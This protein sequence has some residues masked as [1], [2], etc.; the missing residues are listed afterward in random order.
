MQRLGNLSTA[1]AQL[2]RH[3]KRRRRTWLGALVG[4]AALLVSFGVSAPSGAGA[5]AKASHAKTGGSLTVLE[6]SS[7]SGEWPAGFDPLNGTG[8]AVQSQEDAIYGGLFEWGPKNTI[9]PDLAKSWTFTHDDTLLTLNLRPGVTFQDGT[10][11]DAAAVVYNWE[12][13]L[14]P[15]NGCICLSSF[16]VAPNGITATGPLQVQMKLAH[17]YAAL[18]NAFIGEAPN[19]IA[20]PTAE[21]KLGNR[22]TFYPVGAGPFQVVSD[23]TSDEL[24]LKAFPHYWNKGHPYL[25]HLIFK[26]VTGGDQ[27]AYEAM[28]AGD[29]GVY[30]GLSTFSL[31]PT[32]KKHFRVTTEP[33]TSVLW[34]QLN[35]DKA[36]FNKLLAREAIYEATNSQQVNKVLDDDTEIPAE[37]FTTPAGLFFTGLKVPGYI[38]Y[39]PAKARASVKKLHGIDFTIGYLSSPTDQVLAEVLAKEYEAVGMKVGFDP[40]DL[41]LEIDQYR[42]NKLQMELATLGAYDPAA[43]LGVSFRLASN[44]PFSFVH[45]PQMDAILNAAASSPVAS[46]RKADYL[47]AEELMTKEA[48]G[49]ML[50]AGPSLEVSAHDVHGPGF[51]SSL[52]AVELGPEIPWED[53]WVG[54]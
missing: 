4:A 24:V 48:Y 9:I 41:A 27:A 17:P 36:P 38:P 12:R 26:S 49:P 21:R 29:G 5:S 2:W 45:N 19:Y 53:I 25:K 1:P 43:G 40:T 13:D 18:I 7:F 15:K 33:G 47:K 42:A 23:T 46:V 16:P 3:P 51:T 44:G 31:E 30:E 35:P 37:G 6:A 28:L 54:K 11:L 14:L 32:V 20:S 39:N 50:G 34:V 52:T 22:F 10:P 8:L